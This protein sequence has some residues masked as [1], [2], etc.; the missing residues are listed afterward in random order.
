MIPS[1]ILADAAV[2]QERVV[3]IQ[4]RSVGVQASLFSP[5]SAK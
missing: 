2:V 4:V 5:V 3:G 1:H